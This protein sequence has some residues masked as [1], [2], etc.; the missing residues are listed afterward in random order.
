MRGFG[1]GL[2]RLGKGLG[3]ALLLA[4]AAALPAGAQSTHT[5]SDLTDRY[6]NTAADCGGPSRPAFLCSGVIFRG[7]RYSTAYHSWD[8]S[9]TS[10]RTGGVSFSYLRADA[11]F[12]NL[13]FN[14]H[15]GY[16][17][18]PI[19][20]A[21]SWAM[22][23]NFVCAF[24]LDGATDARTDQ[25]CGRRTDDTTNRSAPCQSIG[26]LSAEQWLS[27]YQP[28]N[29]STGFRAC[30]FTV[31]DHTNPPQGT[32]YAFQQVIRAMNQLG[33]VSLGQQNEMRAATWA[34]G[35]GDKLP[36]ESFFY[37]ADAGDQALLDARGDQ[38]DYYR[39]TGRFVPVIRMTLPTANKN[40]TFHYVDADQAIKPA[41]AAACPQYIERGSWTTHPGSPHLSL[42]LVPTACARN[43]AVQAA[44]AVF[45]EIQ[46]KFGNTPQWHNPAGMQ[47]QLTCHIEIARHKDEW[48][49]EPD[50]RADSPE[51]TRKE[52]CNPPFV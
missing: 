40:A 33:A 41:A 6:Y 52:D 20:G 39:T 7:T 36:I 51:L 50:R 3:L 29:S 35:I 30:G 21:P 34:Q 45:A 24:P 1:Q 28:H 43:I 44:P 32:A 14:Y 10:V 23:F 11:R 15:N 49:L 37:L 4:V 16:T 19:F 13:A 17:V 5:A 47:A 12:Q 38:A 27:S 2:G 18:Y 9:P 42:S 8:P 22:D 25:G 26:I 46:A 48:N 31:A